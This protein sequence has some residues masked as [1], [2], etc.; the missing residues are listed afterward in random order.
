[1][2]LGSKEVVIIIM[3]EEWI[4]GIEVVMGSLSAGINVPLLQHLTAHQII[5]EDLFSAMEEL[6]VYK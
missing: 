5:S 4:Q 1:M 6:S 2:D 3:G